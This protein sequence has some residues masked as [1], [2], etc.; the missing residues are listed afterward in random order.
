MLLGTH[1]IAKPWQLNE[2]SF[3]N[4]VTLASGLTAPCLIFAGMYSRDDNKTPD[5]WHGGVKVQ[6]R[7][8]A[9]GGLRRDTRR[10]LSQGLHL[11]SMQR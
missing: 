2:D 11:V 4:C 3:P 8:S 6:I 7:K 10:K 9:A 5:G 1:L